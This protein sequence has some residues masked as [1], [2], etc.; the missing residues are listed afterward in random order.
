MQ[1]LGCDTYLVLRVVVFKSTEVEANLCMLFYRLCIYILTLEIQF[2]RGEGWDAINCFNP[3]T[4]VCL[5]QPRTWISN[6]MCPELFVVSELRWEVIV[7]F[8][9]IGG[10]VD[11]YC[12]IFLFILVEETKGDRCPKFIICTASPK[13]TCFSSYLDS[14]WNM[15]PN[16]A[17]IIQV[18]D[19]CSLC[20]SL[21]FFHD[22]SNLFSSYLKEN[23]ILPLFWTRIYCESFFSIPMR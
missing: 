4:F 3:A 5:S 6:V 10:I 15:L 20:Y 16:I 13:L 19:T 21:C 7:H 12:L 18:S 8:V 9:D 1:F 22:S 23:I 14:L 11:H 2:S 17:H